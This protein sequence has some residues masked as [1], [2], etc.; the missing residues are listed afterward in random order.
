MAKFEELPPVDREFILTLN[1]EE[2]VFLRNLVGGLTYGRVKKEFR[3][4]MDDV[5]TALDSVVNREVDVL[6]NF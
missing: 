5:F 3:D 6:E 4:V 1:L 2:A